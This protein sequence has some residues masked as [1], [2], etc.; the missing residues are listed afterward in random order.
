MPAELDMEWLQVQLDDFDETLVFATVSG[1]HLYGFPSADS[2]V[3]I[4][5]AHLLP[6]AEVVRLEEPEQTRDFIDEREG[7]EVDLVSHEL[8]KFLGLMLER[9]ASALEQIFSPHVVVADETFETLKTL[10]AGCVTRNH[11]HHY[12][13]FARSQW[14]MHVHSSRLKP[15]L[16]SFRA[17]LT[18]IHLVSTGEVEANLEVLAEQYEEPLILE[19]IREKR[20]GHET[21]EAPDHAVEFQEVRDRLKVGLH[22]A[23]DSSRLREAPSDRTHRSMSDYLVDR[24]LSYL[25]R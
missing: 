3:D 21:M 16:Y 2:D 12:N 23:F 25:E 4:R 20:G 9:N 1:A 6:T 18:G 15:L 24:R 7:I 13:G 19:L 5:G 14:A 17:Y 11:F 22:Q 8:E 10:A